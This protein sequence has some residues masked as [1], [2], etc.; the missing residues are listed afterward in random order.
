MQRLTGA[1][2]LLYGP[3]GA[4][5]VVSEELVDMATQAAA[6]KVPPS[7][8]CGRAERSGSRQGAAAA[9]SVCSA[10]GASAACEAG[11]STAML[12]TAILEGG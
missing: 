10:G 7:Y 6:A 11:S 1:V 4:P 12:C 2:Q 9:A 3:A 5:W 8:R